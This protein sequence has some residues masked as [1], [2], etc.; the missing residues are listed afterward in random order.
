M[1]CAGLSFLLAYYIYRFLISGRPVSLVFYILVAAI[2][3]VLNMIAYLIFGGAYSKAFVIPEMMLFAMP[4]NEALCVF[5]GIVIS[6]GSR[7]RSVS[8][9]KE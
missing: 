6:I 8:Q 4:L 5:F 3:L 1:V 9:A 2:L 7:K